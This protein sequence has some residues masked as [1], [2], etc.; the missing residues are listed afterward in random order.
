[1]NNWKRTAEC[2]TVGTE[3]VDQE[4]VLNGWV[5]KRRDHGGLIFVDLRDR[6]GIVQ[7]VFNKEL[8]EEN[9]EVAESIR[10]EYVLSVRGMVTKRDPEAVNPKMATGEVEVVCQ[11]I[12]ILNRAKTPVFE[13]ADDVNVEENIRLKYRY[14]DLRRPEMQDNLK[15]RHQVTMT[16]R[17]YLDD[18]G[19]WEIETPMLTKSTPEGAR[20]YLVPSRVNPGAFFALPQSPQIFKQM[21]MVSGTERYFQIA[22]CF[23]DEDLRADRQ[24]EFTQLDM[25][26]SFVDREDVREIVEGMMGTIFDETLGRTLPDQFPSITYADAMD[27]FGTDRPDLRF[28]MELQSIGDLVDGTEFKVFASVLAGGGQIKGINAK[29]CAGYSRRDIDGLMDVTGTYGAKG[30]AWIALTGEE[31]KS[32]IKKFLS[33]E[34][35]NGIIERMDAQTGDLLLFVADKP[36]VVAASLGALRLH[37]GERLNL[38]DPEELNFCWVVDFPLFEY[39]SDEDRYVAIHHMFTAPNPEDLDLL[40]TDPLKVRALA[41]DLV[42]NGIELGGGSIRIHQRDMQKKIFDLVGFSE[43]EAEQKFGFMLDA[44]QYGAPPHGGIAFGLDRMIMLMK[45]RDSIRD[46]IAFPKTQSASDLLVDAPGEVS[47]RQLQELFIR[48]NLPAKTGR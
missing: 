37:L 48:L 43:E 11:D 46:V 29:G 21:L 26:M 3:Q 10:S 17:R 23:R 2:G 42:L 25:E 28:G 4:V 30:L 6:S 33:E 31:I 12:E 40:E 24:P 32:P 8:S 22:R 39:D 7:V 15:L 1:M 34:E 5:N 35:L 19:F 16:M 27:R 38:I 44:F 13:I 18:R 47:S 20:D 41:Y 14:L 9:L 36:P 45:K